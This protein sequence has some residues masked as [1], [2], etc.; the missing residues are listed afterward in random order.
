MRA[1][2]SGGIA[3]EPV[4]RKAVDLQ[5]SAYERPRTSQFQALQNRTRGGSGSERRGKQQSPEPGPPH[6]EDDGERDE[7]TRCIFA[8][9]DGIPQLPLTPSLSGGDEIDTHNHTH[10]TRI[11][12]SAMFCC[13]QPASA[14]A[15]HGLSGRECL[16]EIQMRE[17][18]V[19][20]G[21]DGVERAAQG[22][23]ESSPCGG[24]VRA[25][26]DDVAGDHGDRFSHWVQRLFMG[27]SLATVA[28]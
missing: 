9:G 23:V 25:R 26:V 12:D 11:E 3:E 13:E 10:S 2:R 22:I 15:W 5:Y 14:I 18:H 19:R 17:R 20:R 21:N 1:D 8:A 28:P 6:R 16:A 4:L 7:R 24:V 27:T